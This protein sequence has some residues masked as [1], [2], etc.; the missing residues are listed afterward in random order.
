M[1]VLEQVMMMSALLTD[2]VLFAALAP[3][4]ERRNDSIT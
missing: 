4:Q 3:A 1:K 2:S